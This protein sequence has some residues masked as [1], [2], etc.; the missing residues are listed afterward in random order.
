MDYW[1]LVLRRAVR[2][3][4]T[5]TKRDTWAAMVVL[6]G[7]VLASGILWLLLGYA[8]PDSAMWAR[9]VAAAVPLLTVPIA[10]GMRLARYSAGPA[11]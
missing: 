9:M 3:A 5:D 7:P 10:L 1:R 6:V 8:L 4:V 2:E 11:Q